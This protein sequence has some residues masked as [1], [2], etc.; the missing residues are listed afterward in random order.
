MCFACGN[1]FLFQKVFGDQYLRIYWTDFHYFV[2]NGRYLFLDDRSEPFY[3]L[4]RRCHGN[5]FWSNITIWMSG[6]IASMIDLHR[7]KI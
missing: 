2:P 1:L 3:T 5:Q 7:V 6:F 4:I